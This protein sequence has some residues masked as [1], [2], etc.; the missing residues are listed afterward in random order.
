MPHATNYEMTDDVDED[1]HIQNYLQ[2]HGGL[3]GGQIA[4]DHVFDQ[5]GKADDAVDYE[6]ITDD[7]DLPE[8][9]EATNHIGDDDVVAGETYG[10]TSA[11]ISDL[12]VHAPPPQ[13]NGFH[14]T[15][16]DS[17]VKEHLNGDLFGE[18]EDVQDLF[19]GDLTS[20]PEQ[21]N[22]QLSTERPAGLA[23]PGKSGLALPE[24]SSIYLQPRTHS[25]QHNS[26]SASPPSM[27]DPSPSAR[28][29]ESENSG[30]GEAP[31][32]AR[33]ICCVVRSSPD[34]RVA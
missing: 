4:E 1:R 27:Q 6:D 8:E 3:D 25:I 16:H 23:L 31:T 26:L 18:S 33:A 19:G 10:Q 7:D 28:R 5:A 2:Q 15:L 9:E 30:S 32:P 13:T 22:A 29:L 17:E 34:H 14:T 24:Y 12:P 21:N 11:G 20:S